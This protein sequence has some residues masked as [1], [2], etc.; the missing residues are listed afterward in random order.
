MVKS[1]NQYTL[2]NLYFIIIIKIF[3]YSKTNMSHT[4]LRRKVAIIG[5]GPVGML[6]SLLF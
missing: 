1:I 6:A 4:L 2:L 3:E 5:C